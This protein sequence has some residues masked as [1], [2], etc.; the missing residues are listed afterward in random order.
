MRVAA[1]LAV[2]AKGRAVGPQ[3]A[4]YLPAPFLRV[5]LNEV[6]VLELQPSEVLA[7]NASVMLL[8]SRPAGPPEI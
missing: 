7:R 4:L 6:M 2:H 3:R 1:V 5:G 8:A